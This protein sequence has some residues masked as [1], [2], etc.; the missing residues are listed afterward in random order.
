MSESE[1]QPLRALIGS[2]SD[3]IHLL[4]SAESIPD[5]ITLLVAANVVDFR[6]V[7][8]EDVECA[9]GEEDFISSDICGTKIRVSFFFFFFSLFS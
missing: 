2:I 3:I 4:G 8:D 7:E 6:G 5:L 9:D 1:I